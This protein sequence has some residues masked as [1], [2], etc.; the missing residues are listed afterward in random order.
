MQNKQATN[1]Y[2]SSPRGLYIALTI[3]LAWLLL[4]LYLLGGYSINWHSPLTYLFVLIQTHLYTGLFITAHDAMHGV[5]SPNKKINKAIGQ[6]SALLFAFNSYKRLYPKHHEHHRYV[7]SE[8][9]PD[10]HPSQNFFIWYFSFLKQYV[11]WWQIVAMALTYNL[12]KLVFPQ[13][14]VILFWIVPSLLATFQLFYF[15]TYLPHRGEHKSGDRHKSK[16]QHKNH[17]WAFLSCYFFGYHWEHHQS[18]AT[19]WWQLW[20]KKV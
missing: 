4:L 5:V 12:L 3:V 18:P 13:E 6:L 14:N 8:K 17:I 2:S 19:P 11:S 15:G 9:D 10:Y 1:L 20:K 16:S 7:A